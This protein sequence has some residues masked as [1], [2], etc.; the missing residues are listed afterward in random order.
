MPR[1]T[2]LAIVVIACSDLASA[3]ELCVVCAKPDAT[4]RCTVDQSTQFGTFKFGEEVQGHICTK[5]LT[6]KGSHE[7]CTVVQNANATCDGLPR[8]ITFTDYQQV[9]ASDG[10]STYEPGLLP[11]IGNKITKAW[12]CLT[13]M[14]KDC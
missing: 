4:Y 13:S 6:K 11:T 1:R 7:H 5:V 8:T 2:A 12:I 9:L 14:F 3:G 10:T